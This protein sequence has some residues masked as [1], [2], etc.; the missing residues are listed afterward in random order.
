MKE[1]K[2]FLENYA[3]DKDQEY[4]EFLNDFIEQLLDEFDVHP[5]KELRRLLASGEMQSGK[6]FQVQIIVTLDKKKFL[7][8][9]RSCRVCGCTDNDC[10]KC[11]KKTGSPCHWV[12][13]DLCSAC[14]PSSLN[15][16]S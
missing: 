13:T 11:I 16:T 12:E 10:R 6:S 4:S 2:Q 3:K 9:P 7:S 15:H 14:V 1:L 8:V 5:Y